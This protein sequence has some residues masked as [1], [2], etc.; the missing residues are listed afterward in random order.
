MSAKIILASKSPR[1]KQLL[2][3]AEIAFEVITEDTEE[4]Y[5]DNLPYT[6]VPVY[7]AQQKANAI[8][9]KHPSRTI[10][11]ADT[12]VVLNNEII[13][14]PTSEKHAIEILQK[15]SANTHLVITGVV[16]IHKQQVYTITET[17]EVHFATLKQTEIEYYIKKYKPFDKAGSYAIQE[18]I[19]AHAIQ[20]IKGCFYNVMGL[21]I[22][23]VCEMLKK[24]II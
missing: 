3:L 16:L 21:P 17:T 9:K 5:P 24:N 10:L 23:K 20:S 22:Q 7:I 15:L 1:R 18:W 2:E 6:E 13:G 4:N 8:A 11:A 12:I 19:G 14:K